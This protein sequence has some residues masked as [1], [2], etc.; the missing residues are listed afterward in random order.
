LA[1]FPQEA[2]TA[3]LL[4]Q[5]HRQRVFLHSKPTKADLEALPITRPTNF[6]REDTTAYAVWRRT[7]RGSEPLPVQ[8]AAMGTSSLL[9]LLRMVTT[10]VRRGKNMARRIS[11]WIWAILARLDETELD[12]DNMFILRQFGK[13]A[14]WVRLGF[15]EAIALQT[16]TMGEEF[17]ELEDESL[18][19]G[20]HIES[21][22][23]PRLEQ[24]EQLFRRR[25]TSSPEPPDHDI[26]RQSNKSAGAN[27]TSQHE[28]QIAKHQLLRR[29]FSPNP[30]EQAGGSLI[31][32]AE[33]NKENDEHEEEFPNLNTRATLDMIITIIGEIYGQ[34][35]LLDARLDW[36]EMGQT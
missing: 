21:H 32:R 11:G 34:R 7:I 29:S 6:P 12:S 5:F 17:E 1:F 9:R 3:R 18:P 2:Y 8:L 25:N 36:V 20:S 26:I 30:L 13:K 28:I 16:E 10:Y 4:S 23:S 19:T 15:D 35:D 14:V 31:G 22:G 33:Q 24:E 27:L